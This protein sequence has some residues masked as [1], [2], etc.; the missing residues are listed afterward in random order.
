MLKDYGAYQAYIEN[1][2]VLDRYGGRYKSDSTFNEFLEEFLD[3]RGGAYR[4]NIKDIFYYFI[5]DSFTWDKTREG[6]TYWSDI[7]SKMNR[8]GKKIKKKDFPVSS[9]ELEYSRTIKKILDTDG[10]KD[11]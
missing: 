8:I 7:L 9:E 2:R 11:I 4:N 6:V 3:N 1:F 10:K 5:N